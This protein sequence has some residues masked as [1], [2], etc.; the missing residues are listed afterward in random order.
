MAQ[1]APK[2]HAAVIAVLGSEIIPTFCAWRQNV[3][4]TVFPLLCVMPF[5][6]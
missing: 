1:H 3:A 5:K 6:A 4:Q 2:V